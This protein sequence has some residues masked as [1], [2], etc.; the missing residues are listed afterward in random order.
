MQ[1]NNIT[2][3]P[4]GIF[5][6]GLD[7]LNQNVNGCVHTYVN[8]NQTVAERISKNHNQTVAEQISKIGS[9]LVQARTDNFG[10]GLVRT[11][12]RACRE[13]NINFHSPGF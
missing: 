4:A 11:L 3:Y 10:S 6:S 1:V 5:D 12:Y 8:H 13:G 2:E 9:G 7:L